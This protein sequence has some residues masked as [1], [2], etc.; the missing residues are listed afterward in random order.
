VRSDEDVVDS[1]LAGDRPAYAE[2]VARY[3]R[4]VHA[5][6]WAVLRDHHASQDVTQDAFIA[7]YQ[8]LPTLRDRRSFGP[9]VVTIA[10]RAAIDRAR[11]PA[12]PVHAGPVP[13]DCPA[14]PVGDPP[15][16]RPARVLAA[17]ARLPDHEQRAVLLRY[18]DGRPTAEIARLTGRSV[19]TVTKQLTRALRRL[20]ETLEDPS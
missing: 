18:I 20:R 1:V 10:R 2:L 12:V 4:A 7:A 13:A 11:R 16:D 14:P 6:A 19:G 5:A 3:E 8:R 9:W 15:D 17:V